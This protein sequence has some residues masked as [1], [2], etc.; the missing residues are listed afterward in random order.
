[1]LTSAISIKLTGFTPS[2]LVV[3]PGTAITWT[4]DTDMSQ[5]V[6]ARLGEWRSGPLAPGKPFTYVF[7]LE[8]AFDF[9]APAAPG[10]LGTVIVS[11]HAGKPGGQ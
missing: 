5:T 6:A 11:D 2:R 9:V 4:N 8:G 10:L 1:M 7:R 3:Q